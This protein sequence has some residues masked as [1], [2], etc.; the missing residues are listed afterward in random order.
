MQ[1]QHAFWA[2]KADDSNDQTDDTVLLCITTQLAYTGCSR[3]G[4]ALLETQ[5]MQH[6]HQDVKPHIRKNVVQRL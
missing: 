1:A 2:S 3:H 6:I 5:S 4:L